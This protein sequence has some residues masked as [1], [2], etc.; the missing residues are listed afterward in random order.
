MAYS[1]S[2]R[3]EN[4]FLQGDYV[5]A[6]FYY[7]KALIIREQRLGL[8]HPHTASTYYALARLYSAAERYGEAESFFCLAL[9]IRESV[10]GDD[11]PMVANTLE[12]YA[13]T[14]RKQQ[15]EHEAV[16]LEERIQVI[17]ARQIAPETS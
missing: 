10:F 12:L 5:Q 14:L 17:K 4:F 15:R 2:N 8:D 3:A 13:A 16:E 11:H 6:E 1:F 9:P 7:K